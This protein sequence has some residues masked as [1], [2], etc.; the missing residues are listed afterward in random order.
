MACSDFLCGLLF[1]TAIFRNYVDTALLKRC[2]PDYIPWM[3]VIGALLT[4]VVFAFADRVARRFS[5]TYLMI[6]VVVGYAAGVT[7]CWLMVKSKFTIVY[8]ILYQLMGL[9]ESILLV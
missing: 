5:D 4:M 3:L 6:S 8:P 9:L 1:V 7:L 2:G